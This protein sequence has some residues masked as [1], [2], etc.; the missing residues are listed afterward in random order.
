MGEALGRALG[1]GEIGGDASR[2][3]GEASARSDGEASRDFIALDLGGGLSCC[4]FFLVFGCG[5]LDDILL[6]LGG[7]LSGFF[8][9]F[10]GLRDLFPDFG[11][12]AGFFVVLR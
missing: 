9:F 2:A 10:R 3:G 1:M 7:E 8:K 4:R 11:L 12:S 5:L 6:D